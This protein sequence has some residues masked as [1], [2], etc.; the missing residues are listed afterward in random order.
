ML[1]LVFVLVRV[2]ITV[3]KHHGQKQLGWRRLISAYCSGHTSL[4]EDPTKQLTVLWGLPTSPFPVKPKGQ[5]LPT[6]VEEMEEG[7]PCRA[8][9]NNSPFTSLIAFHYYSTRNIFYPNVKASSSLKG[10]CQPWSLRETS[11]CFIGTTWLNSSPGQQHDLAI[12]YH[13]S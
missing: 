11:A 1:A 3:I 10:E 2:S 8:I 7:P 13:G 12:V 4:L 9:A 5:L 6:I